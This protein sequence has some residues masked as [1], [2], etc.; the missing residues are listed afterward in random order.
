MAL[1]NHHKVSFALVVVVM[2]IAA[3]CKALSQAFYTDYLI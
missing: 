1:N 3:M 2:M